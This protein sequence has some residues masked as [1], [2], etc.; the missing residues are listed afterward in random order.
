MSDTKAARADGA[1]FRDHPAEATSPLEWAVAALGLVLIVGAIGYLAYFALTT[2]PEP[3]SVFVTRQSVAPSGNGYVVTITA[4]NRGTSTA[5]AVTVEGTL[6]Q[7]GTPIETSEVTLDYLPRLS[8]RQ[9]GLF[10]T[11]DPS[12]YR[13]ELRPKGYT[14]P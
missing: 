2:R 11:H 14:E 12:Q 6:L 3:P 1:R 10:F 7:N 9:A 8:E 13:L 4:D 5:A